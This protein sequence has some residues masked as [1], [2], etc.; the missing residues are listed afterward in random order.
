MD[1]DSFLG[2]AWDEHA[3]DPAAVARRL[4]DDALPRLGTPA[5]AAALASLAHHVWGE[6]LGDWAAGREFL[7]RLA[8]HPACT[9]DAAAPAV[10]RCLASLAL[11]EGRHDERPAFITSDRIRITAMAAANLAERD[12]DRASAW[13]GEALAAAGDLDATDPA[14]RALAV[15]GNNL[16][17]TLEEKTTRTPAERALMI[18]AAQAARHHWALAGT[19]LETERAEYRL[20]M[21]WLQAGEPATALQHA[22]QCLDIVERHGG[23]GL[24]RFFAW[25]AIG[26]AARA[27]GDAAGHG[28]AL[29]H[30]RA[31]FAALDE[32]DQGWCRASLDKLAG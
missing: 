25:E 28:Q 9:A 12:T 22:R 6:H 4:A 20:A 3:A 18:R 14:H 2:Q 26:L 13:F 1:F 17:S 27:A 29:D 10:R 21:S 32:G 7:Q 24:E 15:T 5:Q 16:A 30:A 8:Q 11:C 23:A 19:W 31:A